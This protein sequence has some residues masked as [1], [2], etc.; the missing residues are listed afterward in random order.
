M[1]EYPRVASLKTAAAF[2]AHLDRG[3]I[4]IAFDDELAAPGQSPLAWQGGRLSAV[5]AQAA[6]DA[7]RS[8]LVR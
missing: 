5:I 7:G 4:R 1:P 8:G 6:S 2:R 3:A